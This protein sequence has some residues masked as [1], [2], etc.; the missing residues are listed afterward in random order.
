V[1]REAKRASTLLRACAGAVLCTLALGASAAQALPANFWGVVPQAYPTLEQLQRLRRGGARSIRIPINWNL[2][3]PARNAPIG[4]AG[5]DAQIESASLAGLSVLPFL[6]GAPQWAVHLVP[7]PGAGGS[8]KASRNLPVSGAAAQGWSAFAAAAVAR[9]GPHGS[10]WLEHPSVPARPIRNW[11]IWNEENFEYFVAHPNPAEYGKLVKLSASAIKAA[12]PGA[13]VI[14]GGLFARPREAEFR[15]KPPLAYFATDFLAQMYERTP[16]IKSKFQG[17]ALHPYT[18]NY[19]RLTPYVE[20]LRAVLAANHDAGKGL[21]ITELGWSSEPPAPNNSFAKGRRGQA[22]QLKGAFRLLRA[23]QAQW[24]V[25]QVDW[26]SVDD[27]PG[28][29]NFCDGSGLFAQGFVPKPAWAAF[30]QLAGGRP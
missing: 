19:K 15:R 3:Q 27:Q 2:L 14:L 9:Y 30:A 18:S 24:H 13:R 21:W 20:E 28:A 12:D 22:T 25:Q 5:V 23:K 11:Q 6:V 29:C 8:L 7:V 1:A 4:W 16:G 26:F 10:F 17:V